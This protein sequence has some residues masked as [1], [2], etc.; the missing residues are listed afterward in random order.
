VTP[1]KPPM[2]M[3]ELTAAHAGMRVIAP[4]T[5]IQGWLPHLLLQSVEQ[6]N[7]HTTLM[8]RWDDDPSPSNTQRGTFAAGVSVPSDT[9]CRVIPPEETRP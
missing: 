2:V 5:S 6:R 9:P 7:G 1:N 8:F 4:L 3:R